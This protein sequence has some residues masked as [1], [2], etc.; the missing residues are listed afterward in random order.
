[1]STAWIMAGLLTDAQALAYSCSRTTA[2]IAHYHSIFTCTYSI[3]FF[4][5][6]HHGS[7][8]ASTLSSLQ[9]LVSLAVPRKILQTESGLI[10]GLEED[11]ETLQEIA[12]QF[13]PLMKHFRIFFF[14]EQ[15]RTDLKHTKDYIVTEASAAPM[16]DDTERS[17]IAADHRGMCRFDAKDAPGFR[18]VV[19][20]LRRYA[21]DAPRVVETRVTRTEAALREQRRTDAENMLLDIQIGEHQ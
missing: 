2:K 5:T 19:A 7:S 8:K 14:W 10:R 17:G 13:A 1:M 4:G 6:P 16:L 18:T 9:R 15:E 3:V 21:H 12:D 20:A 11:C